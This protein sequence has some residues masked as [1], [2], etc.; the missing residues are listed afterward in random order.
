LPPSV[1]GVVATTLGTVA[2]TRPQ[3]AAL[4]V[5]ALAALARAPLR[6]LSERGRVKV[7]HVVRTALVVVKR[8]LTG[9]VSMAGVHRDVIIDK[10]VSALTELGYY[11]QLPG[12][13]GGGARQQQSQ[14]R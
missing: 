8:A 10:C 6:H 1:L 14:V 11:R 5:D 12:G 7:R 9:V 2:R 4:S 13:D 3:F